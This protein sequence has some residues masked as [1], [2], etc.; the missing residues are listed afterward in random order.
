MSNSDDGIVSWATVIQRI[1]IGVAAAAT[2]G[3]GSM[4]ISSNTRG[5]VHEE[6]IGKLEENLGKLPDIDHNLV[7]LS[8]KVDVLNQK[9]DDAQAARQLVATAQ[10]PVKTK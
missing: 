3:A 10:G 8:G 5:L 9:L 2:I 6:R 7:V 4:V 1:A